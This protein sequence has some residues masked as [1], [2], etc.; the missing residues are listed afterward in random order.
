MLNVL[1][2][3]K[4][5]NGFTFE[6]VNKLQA[7]LKKHLPIEHA[8]HCI[9]ETETYWNAPYY[10]RKL[11]VL[12]VG[13]PSIYFDLDTIILKNISEISNAIL[14]STE[15]IF[16]MI[17]AF[18]NS[19][20]W[21]SGIMAWNFD[22]SWIARDCTQDSIKKYGKWEQDFI[23]DKLTERGIKIKSLNDLVKIY[24]F[25]HHCKP[26]DSHP[27]DAQ[28]ICYHGLPRPKETYLWNYLN[29]NKYNCS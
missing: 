23:S 10:W 9:Q 24:S 25:K 4:E 17:N 26:T 7:D 8:L 3:Y 15:D 18:S 13:F 11:D 16:Y 6:Y 27:V 19:R 28:I 12:R 1:C 29:E 14:N 21:A 22:C 2:Y 20:K 5:G